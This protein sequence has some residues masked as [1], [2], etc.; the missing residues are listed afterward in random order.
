MFSSSQS[1]GGFFTSQSSQPSDAGPSPSRNRGSQTTFP[2]TVKQISQASDSAEDRSIYQIDGVDVTNVKM[3]GMVFD[4]AERVTDVTFAFDDGTG[5]IGCKR[6]L[7]ELFDRKQM[8]AIE[9][10]IYVQLIG[11]LKSFQDRPQIVA[12]SLRPVTNFN[13]ISHHFI[14]CIHNH[15]QLSRVKGDSLTQRQTVHSSQSLPVKSES[16]GFH[17]TPPNQLSV[18]MSVDGL[19]ACDQMILDYLQQ[20]SNLAQ[21][22]GIH[23]DEIARHLKLP[24]EKIMDSI[25]CLEG[26]GLIYST[27]DEFHF[28]STAA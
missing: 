11:H 12:F 19:K 21:E 8:E 2:V 1:D 9:D 7:N 17:S 14:E 22:K 25:A 20:P 13:E 24:V 28:K 5:R 16:N 26:E 10:G 18:Q 6:W 4:K 23:R 27:I 15:A 3:V